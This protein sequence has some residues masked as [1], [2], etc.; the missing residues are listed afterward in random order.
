VALLGRK[1]E[2]RPRRAGEDETLAAAEVATIERG[3]M[4]VDPG[5]HHDASGWHGDARPCDGRLFEEPPQ[6][7]GASV[8]QDSVRTTCEQ[9]RG[10]A[11]V[12][13]GHGVA[14]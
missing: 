4:D 10:V 11:S 8:A 1:I 7:R 2:N 9:R 13:G 5:S 14:N 12:S 6:H 3:T